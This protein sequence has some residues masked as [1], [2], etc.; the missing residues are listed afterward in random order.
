MRLK[1][2]DITNARG[3]HRQLISLQVTGEVYACLRWN[4]HLIFKR[5]SGNRNA[6]AEVKSYEREGWRPRRN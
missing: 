1:G 4:I 5:A 3:T 6:A 2:Q